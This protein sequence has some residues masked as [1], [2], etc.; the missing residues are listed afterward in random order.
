MY[1]SWDEYNKGTIVS[2]G[3]MS[4]GG[5]LRNAARRQTIGLTQWKLKWKYKIA[6]L[7]IFA[8]SGGIVFQCFAR[9]TLAG[10]MKLGTQTPQSS[11]SM[12]SMP[13]DSVSQGD[14][15]FSAE[16]ILPGGL[17][18]EES[19]SQQTNLQTE[20]LQEDIPNEQRLIV[21]DPGH[22]GEDEGGSIQGVLEKDLNLQIAQKVKDQLEEMGY[23]VEMTRD[24]DISLR[25][26]ERT[27]IANNAKADMFISIHQNTS[28][29]AEAE[30]IETWYCAELRENRNTA[31]RMAALIHKYIIQK[32]EARDRGLRESQELYVIRETQMPSC[33]IETGFLTNTAECRSLCTE[34][35]QEQLAEGIARGIDIS[36]HPRT[37]YLTFD[38]GPSEE[39]TNAILDILKERNIK[40]TFFLVGENVEKY[41]ETAKRIAEEGHTIAIHCYNHDYEKLYQSV[42]SYLEDFYKAYDTIYQITGIQAKLFRFPGG[43]INAYNQEVNAAIIQELT[44]QGFIYYDWNASLEDAVKKSTPE[45]LIANAVESTLGRKRIILLAHDTV[46]NTRLCLEELLDSLPE[47]NFLPMTDNT[48]PIQF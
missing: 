33:L 43:S 24:T 28:D 4:G 36:L 35:Y 18:Q 23:R 1:I 12:N 30:G 14:T 3:G 26:E 29:A 47:Y 5:C 19:I 8:I 17:N 22:G 34:D 41:P 42:D 15:V 2:R 46:Y 44:E 10:G 7:L 37:L 38:D 21:L 39:N 32:T 25:L 20:L 48:I 6:V 27:A 9:E 16:S 13:M 11:V 31:K 45:S 40:A